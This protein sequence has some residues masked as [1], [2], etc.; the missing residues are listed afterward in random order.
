[1]QSVKYSICYYSLSS[2]EFQLSRWRPLE[3]F[4]SPPPRPCHPSRCLSHNGVLVCSVQSS[5]C[6]VVLNRRKSWKNSVGQNL[7]GPIDYSVCIVVFPSLQLEHYKL[8]FKWDSWDWHGDFVNCD[9]PLLC[10]ISCEQ[11]VGIKEGAK[12]LLDP[13]GGVGRGKFHPV[14]WAVESVFVTEEPHIC[15][16]PPNIHSRF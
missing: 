1:M 4:T 2:T 14:G 10:F 11:R 15:S 5:E 6:L 13:I 8:F 7:T 3:S 16:C 12:N 9:G